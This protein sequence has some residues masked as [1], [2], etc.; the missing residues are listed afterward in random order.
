MYI[1]GTK[2]NH[3]CVGIKVIRHVKMYDVWNVIILFYK[4]IIKPT[5]Y[6]INIY[7]FVQHIIILILIYHTLISNDIR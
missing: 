3:F 5:T 2:Y 1:Q 4:N 6:D 7:L